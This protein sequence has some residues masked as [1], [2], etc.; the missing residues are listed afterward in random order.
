MRAGALRH[1]I[2]IQRLEEIDGPFHKTEWVDYRTNVPASFSFLS[3]K[4]L[5]ASG[6]ELS[7]VSARIQVRY[8]E[9]IDAKMRV[10]YRNKV[11]EIEAVVPDNRSGMEWL[12][13]FVNEGLTD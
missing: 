5:V 7:Q 12:T 3:G 10:I 11:Y 9:N 6:A 2:T 1:R 4:E 13:L 8:D